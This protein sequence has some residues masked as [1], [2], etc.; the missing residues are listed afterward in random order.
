MNLIENWARVLWRSASLWCLYIA[1][2]TG[3]AHQYIQ[4]TDNGAL[5]D[6]WIA[7]VDGKLLAVMFIFG[8]LA[9]P[10]RIINQNGLRPPRR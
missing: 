10:A 5:P 1:G 6:G 9:I 7:W 2:I 3:A 4:Q 8:A